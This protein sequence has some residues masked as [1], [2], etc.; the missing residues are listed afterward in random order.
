[1]PVQP[2]ADRNF[3]HGLADFWTAFFSD[4]QFTEAYFQAGQVMLGQLYLELLQEVLGT[5][6]DHA[7]L[8]SKQYYRLFLIREDQLRF[9]EGRS[10]ADDRYKYRPDEPVVS[11]PTLMNKVIAPTAYLFDQA[12]YDVEGGG[13]SFR[14]HPFDAELFPVRSVPVTAPAMAV[15]PLGTDWADAGVKAG[16]TLQYVLQSAPA[17][18]TVVRYVR[19]S[20][21]MLDENLAGF[22]SELRGRTASLRVMRTPFDSD[23]RG[24]VVPGSPSSAEVLSSLSLVSGTTTIAHPGVMGTWLGRYV[25]V[26][27]AGAAENS[28]LYRVNS[29]NVLAGTATIA[30]P[31]NF[32]PTAGAVSAVLLRYGPDVTGDTPATNL[33]HTYLTPGSISA[34]GR[35]LTERVVDGIVYPADGLLIEGVDFAVNYETGRLSFLSAWDPASQARLNYRWRLLVARED[36]A[37]RLAWSSLASYV[38]G[39]AVAHGDGYW[40]CIVSSATAG[41]FELTEWVRYELFRFDESIDV[42]EL[43][44]WAP[45]VLID[46][47]RLYINFGYLLGYRRPSSEQYRAFLKG[48]SHLFLLGPSIARMR[49]ALNVMAGLPVIRQDGERFKEYR[50]G[51]EL[52]NDGGALA[53]LTGDD[54]TGD[55]GVLIDYGEGIDGEIDAV[56]GTFHS[57]T[58]GFFAAD[59]IGTVI[60]VTYEDEVSDYSVTAISADGLTA[61]LAPPPTVSRSPVR[62]SYRHNTANGVFRVESSLVEYLFSESDV[63]AALVISEVQGT[64]WQSGIHYHVGYVANHNGAAY[65]CTTDNTDVSF[66]PSHWRLL[67]SLA[68]RNVGTFRILGVD[69]PRSLRLESAFGFTDARGLRWKITHER[70]QTVVTDRGVYRLPLGVPVRDDIRLKEVGRFKAYEHLTDAIRVVDYV[71]DPTWWHRV[72]IPHELLELESENAGRRQVTPELIPNV[73]DPV[74]GAVFDDPGL[75]FDADD[76]LE[77][78][79][80]REGPALWL[81]GPWVQ[82][83]FPGGTLSASPSDIGQSLVFEAPPF[84]GAYAITAL[85]PGNSVQLD[86]F[87]PPEARHITPLV[88]IDRVQLPA[89]VFRRSV[90]FV[91][92]D[93]FLKYHALRAEI[94]LLPDFPKGFLSDAAGLLGGGKPGY[95]YLFVDSSTA[96]RD[97]V[98]VVETFTPDIGH[99]WLDQL[100]AVDNRLMFDGSVYFNEYYRF[101]NGNVTGTNPTGG[102][103]VSFTVT[104]SFPYSPDR[105]LFVYAKFTQGTLGG[106]LLALGRDY[107]FNPTTGAVTVPAMDAGAYRFDYVVVGLKVHDPMPTPW[108]NGVYPGETPICFDGVNP[109]LVRAAGGTE[110]TEGMLERAIQ[111]TIAVP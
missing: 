65:A 59:D 38:R 99:P 104:P 57:P 96:L 71:V 48:A 37:G 109:T 91:M 21:M 31:T 105:Y 16:D 80:V 88:P 14:E 111:I 50:S 43:A 20:R 23:Q 47:N 3:L 89:I 66:D 39:D 87:P 53:P 8:F 74:D 18:E 2:D 54:L 97:T 7:P 81:G 86:R 29:V 102:A 70:S 11:A 5:S 51:Y 30:R 44:A 26:N 62:W 52:L 15:S 4:T 90:A 98:R 22:G 32:V 17:V 36:Y 46:R 107:S 9:S 41:S 42:R 35:R 69:G 83:L 78:G 56:A 93:R 49:S 64:V 84:T 60:R 1:M 34:S 10:T 67:G 6:L 110:T 12:D 85:G 100:A 94:D 73:F 79:Y 95:T 33:P 92:M 108:W 19:G 13:L 68:A 72:T 82:L 76:N 45:D 24:V 106:K 63:D 101:S 103:P 75:F 27:D 58:A 40:V 25:Y 61:T 55:G 77:P 28:G